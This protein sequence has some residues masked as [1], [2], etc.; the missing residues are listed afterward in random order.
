MKE[1]KVINK[2][3]RRITSTYTL[4]NGYRVKLSTSHNGNYKVI[5]SIVS[6]CLYRQ[7]LN[8]A[9][10]THRVFSD[11]SEIVTSEKVARYSFDKLEEVHALALALSADTIA[12]LLNS[13]KAGERECQREVA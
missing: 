8:Y 11:F 6:E 4:D 1:D 9:M 7:E 3:S 10:E 2:E 12:G 5:R 13:G